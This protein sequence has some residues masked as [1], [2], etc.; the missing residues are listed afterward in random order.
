MEI[1][2]NAGNYLPLG[3]R[4]FHGVLN[5]TFSTKKIRTID[6]AYENLPYKAYPNDDPETDARE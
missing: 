1:R 6:Q 4:A 3:G 2:K 5:S